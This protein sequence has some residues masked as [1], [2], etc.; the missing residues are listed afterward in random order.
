MPRADAASEPA[1]GRRYGTLVNP[2]VGGRVNVQLRLFLP[3][4]ADGTNRLS[5]Y[6]QAHASDEM[7]N[8]QYR[9]ADGTARNHGGN[10]QARHIF[11]V[12]EHCHL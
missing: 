7:D 8:G 1:R 12:R 5:S 9:T 11:Q 10:L 3:C 6:V 2:L 4:A